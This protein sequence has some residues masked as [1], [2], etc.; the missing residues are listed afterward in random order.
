M[1]KMIK[2]MDV[3]GFWNQLNELVNMSQ[4]GKSSTSIK[5]ML[6]NNNSPEI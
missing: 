6:K 5:K 2:F 1:I 4:P 3:M